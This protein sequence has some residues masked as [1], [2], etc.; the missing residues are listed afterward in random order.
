MCMLI[1]VIIAM[2]ILKIIIKIVCF[3]HMHVYITAHLPHS[4][5]FA[6]HS[7]A[8]MMTYDGDICISLCGT[9]GLFIFVVGAGTV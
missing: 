3:I 1:L 5:V 9:A 8:C 6:H 4:W 2:M 7:F